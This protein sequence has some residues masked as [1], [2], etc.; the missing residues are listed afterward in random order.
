MTFLHTLN[1]YRE[2]RTFLL[3]SICFY[4]SMYISKTIHALW[5]DANDALPYFGFSYTMMAVAGSLSIISGKLSDIISP[6][7]AL[8]LGVAVYAV[9]LFL[10]I[11]THSMMIS[12]VSGFVAGLGASL[13]IV[14]MRYWILSIGTE[15][16]RP[17]IVSIKETGTNIGITVGTSLAG[18]LVA[19]LSLVMIEP[20]LG[21]LIFSAFCCLATTLLVPNTL[22]KD[23]LTKENRQSASKPTIIKSHKSLTIGIVIFG[24]LTGL[25]VSLFTPYVPIILK[26]QGIN[27]T[28]IGVYMAIVSMVGI[29]AAPLFGNSKVN[30]FKNVIFFTCELLTGL[31]ILLFLKSLLATVILIILIFR[32]ILQTGSV[33]TQELME[34]EIYPKEYL[35]FLFGA[36]QSAFFIGDALGGTL[37]G[38][39]YDLDM[40][41]ALI[42]CTVLFVI[43][44]MAFPL[45]YKWQR[46]MMND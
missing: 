36:S 27:I 10:R 37:G 42:I 14:S 3:F 6:S 7:F 21:V 15:E 41:Y 31:L 38:Y 34:L 23:K 13:V 9:G 29:V 25:S 45:F 2:A 46:A 39:V 17:A 24:L 4:I 43:N 19:I 40:K 18:G 22:R 12:G 30:Q 20:I 33:I 32:A 16:E 8:K 5:F 11:F 1:K 28:L 35:G 26:E 44:A